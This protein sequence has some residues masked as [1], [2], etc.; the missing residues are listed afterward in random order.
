MKSTKRYQ[1]N[2]IPVCVRFFSAFAISLKMNA[3][4]KRR[5][6]FLVH[7]VL[8]RDNTGHAHATNGGDLA[9]GVHF[10]FK[11]INMIKIDYY[12]KTTYTIISKMAMPWTINVRWHRVLVLYSVCFVYSVK[13]RNK[14][15]FSGIILMRNCFSCER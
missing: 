5:D 1:L 15:G 2:G 14:E 12:I 9:L 10:F 3:D 7:F 4:E 13:S 6:N 11:W 8:T